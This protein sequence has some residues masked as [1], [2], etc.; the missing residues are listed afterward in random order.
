MR[1]PKTNASS[2]FPKFG[3]FKNFSFI[4]YYILSADCSDMTARMAVDGGLGDPSRSG[5]SETNPFDRG[6]G[7]ISYNSNSS[8]FSIID[9]FVWVNLVTS[10]FGVVFV[11]SYLS[12]HERCELTLLDQVLQRFCTNPSWFFRRLLQS[13]WGDTSQQN[14]EN[15]IF[16]IQTK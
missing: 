1:R 16:L 9:R 10:I 14:A 4:S 2:E 7:E 5:R 3:N 15:C 8:H 6:Y 11:H 13:G 12:V